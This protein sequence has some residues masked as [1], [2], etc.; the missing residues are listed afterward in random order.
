[1]KT[2][3]IIVGDTPSIETGELGEVLVAVA[4]KDKT[5]AEADL[6]RMLTSPTENDLKLIGRAINL[7]VKE[8]ESD[9]CWWNWDYS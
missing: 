3:F 6:Q 2:E 9:K 4:G 8:V 7:R 1:M 5:Q